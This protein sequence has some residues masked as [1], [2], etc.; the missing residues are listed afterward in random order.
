[1][2]V[3]LLSTCILLCL[4]FLLGYVRARGTVRLLRAELRDA[5]E[6]RRSQ[7]SLLTQRSQLDTLK[8][9]F[10][11]T[12]SHEFRTPL[13]SIHGAL[14]LLFAGHM[15]AVDAK[16][17]NLLRIALN[18]TDRLI[19]L[20]N[21]ILDL[22]RM[23]SGKAPLQVRRC[24]IHELAQQSIDTMSSMAA[25]A[26]VRLDL[27][28]GASP[29][30]M[31]F[32]GDS[33]RILQVLSNLLSNGIKFSPPGSHV[34]LRI[35]ADPH[36]LL[37]RVSD[38]GRGIPVEM[39]DSVFDRFQQV[40]AADFRQKGGSGLGLAICRSIVQQHSGVIWAE[41]NPQHGPGAALLLTVPRICRLHDEPLIRP[42]STLPIPTQSTVRIG[43]GLPSPV[44]RESPRALA[45]D[46][47]GHDMLGAKTGA[48]EC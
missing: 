2:N 33:D 31:F 41:S 4:A 29:E 32:D 18:N 34:E 22:E 30:A 38:S 3:V 21:D 19:R 36:N 45:Y 7:F 27:V 28:L 16:S 40:D 5:T 10:I 25:T 44:L 39:L 47:R 9:E 43:E 11:C 23:Q 48:Q 35:E 1:M 26:Q 14:V 15:G 17:Q 8:D 37:I 6:A 24:S 12:A 46:M 20:I 42:V 13:T